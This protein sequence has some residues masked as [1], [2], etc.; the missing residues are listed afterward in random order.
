MDQPLKQSVTR[1]FFGELP[2][3]SIAVLILIVGT[4]F[5]N[6]PLWFGLQ[7]MALAF[8]QNVTYSLQSR[9]GNRSSNLYHLVATILATFVFF[10]SLSY[11]IHLKVT[12]EVLLTYILG[13]M[14]G[15]LYGTSLSKKIESAL[16]AVANLGEEVKGQ[17]LP[18]S[19]AVPALL[20]LLGVE[21]VVI[22]DYEV[23]AMAIIA[24]ASFVS[25]LVFAALRAARNTNGYWFHLVLVIIHSIAG[26]LLYDTLTKT[27]GSWY[28]FAPYV[29]GAVLGSLLGAESGKRFLKYAGAKWDVVEL[30]KDMIPLPSWP[31][32]AVLL[33][34]VPHMYYFGPIDSS[35]QALVLISALAM[36]SAAT[37]VS[38]ARQRG[39][40]KYLEW[41]SVFSNG[42]WFITLHILVVNRLP[43]HFFV[44]YI[45]GTAIGSLWGQAFSMWVEP[46]I[47]ATM[48]SL[49][50]KN[51]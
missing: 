19:H 30:P 14:L 11:L 41:A 26:F 20:I 35:G 37:V 27:N 33:L 47:G 49:P 50:Q 16:G 44:P 29:T 34:L 18:L 48:D 28:L 17:K 2:R 24:M 23:K 10:C 7:I 12:Y 32:I 25:S 13:T 42:I 6:I 45:V 38:R 8:V 39:H 5:P 46:R 36:T 4:V 40:M 22:S 15:S 21:L 9:A 1:S 51:A 31:V 43:P 3:P